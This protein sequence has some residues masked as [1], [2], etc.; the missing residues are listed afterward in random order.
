MTM[1]LLTRSDL[2]P[3]I[4]RFAGCHIFQEALQ[5][6]SKPETL[7]SLLAQYV[8]F[9]AVF[10]GGVANLSGE[11]AVRLDLFVDKNEA[12]P[13]VADRS[14]VVAAG[15]FHAS[16]DAFQERSIANPGTHRS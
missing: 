5:R 14:A 12:L 11:I 7:I 8:R 10:A 1:S 9:N 2:Q 4:E 13:F 3:S 15:V 16:V 6:A